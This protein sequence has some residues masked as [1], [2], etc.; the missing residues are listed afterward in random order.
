MGDNR[1]DEVHKIITILV[2][3]FN[4]HSCVNQCYY[5]FF[6]IFLLE[7][8]NFIFLLQRVCVQLS[9]NGCVY[10]EFNK[11]CLNF[12]VDFQEEILE[13][14]EESSRFLSIFKTDKNI[15]TMTVCMN[16]IML[17]KHLEERC[18]TYSCNHLI[19]RTRV[20]HVVSNRKSVYKSLDQDWLFCSS[21]HYLWEIY[22]RIESE[23]F[24]KC[25]HILCLNSKIYLLGQ[26]SLHW[27]RSYRNLK[28]AW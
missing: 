28:S 3:H 26:S 25:V 14:V 11:C 18:C 15:P 1:S 12:S 22:R 2:I 10:I 6:S 7:L 23:I 9:K 19:Q 20:L 8:S 16:K 24:T 5:N 4:H 27:F 21:F 17:H 13:I